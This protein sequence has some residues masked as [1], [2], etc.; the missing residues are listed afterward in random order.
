M[1]KHN[2]ELFTF[3]DN[4]AVEPTNN[5]AE[6]QLRPNVI[7][8]KVTFGNRSALGAFNHAVIMSIIQTG[9]LNGSII[10]FPGFISKALN[11]IYGIAK[12]K[13]AMN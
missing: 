2:Q 9:I 10:D 3:L 13:V 7:M 6:R 8:R 5:R 4:P 12:D 11:F 1:I